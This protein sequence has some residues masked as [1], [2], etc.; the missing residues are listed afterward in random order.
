MPL[1]NHFITVA[2]SSWLAV[3]PHPTAGQEKSSCEM[4][5]TLCEIAEID[6]RATVWQRIREAWIAP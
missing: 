6:R 1:V 5:D 2:A 3:N 4:F